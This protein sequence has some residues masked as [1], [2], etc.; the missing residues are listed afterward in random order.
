MKAPQIYELMKKL[1]EEKNEKYYKVGETC[2]LVTKGMLITG[3]YI[4][5]GRKVIVASVVLSKKVLSDIKSASIKEFDIVFRNQNGYI[6]L[7]KQSGGTVNCT[8]NSDFSSTECTIV[9]EN[10]IQVAFNAKEDF[11]INGSQTAVTNNTPIAL[12]INKLI[13]EFS[14][15]ASDESIEGPEM[16]D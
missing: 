12:Q 4:S 1:K 9:S 15:I 5:G 6:T 11:V 14:D 10:T 7:P 8:E 2:N 16:F 3:G 13:L